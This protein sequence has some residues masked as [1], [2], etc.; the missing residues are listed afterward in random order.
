MSKHKGLGRGLDALLGGSTARSRAVDA[1]LAQVPASNVV[2][3]KTDLPWEELAAIP[4]SLRRPA[5]RP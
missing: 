3:I 1:E 2:A 5:Q 4:E